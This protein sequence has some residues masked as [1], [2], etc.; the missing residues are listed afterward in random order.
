M[1]AS[2]SIQPAAD[3]AIAGP[4]D[5]FAWSPQVVALAVRLYLAEGLSA[6]EVA[7]ALG[8]GLTRCAVIAKIRRLGLR[9]RHDVGTVEAAT[10]QL[11]FRSSG[12]ATAARAASRM[13]A[14]PPIPLPPLREVPPTG[15]PAP[16][17]LLPDGRCRWPVDDP[18]PSRMHALLFC[19]GV[20]GA[21][22]YC[23]AHE[24]LAARQPTGE[25]Q[26]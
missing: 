17:V 20:T 24:A 9:K 26:A 18:G 4:P 8:G 7:A 25:G 12:R 11:G 23:A 13:P 5:T 3:A 10:A 6:S 22:R 2:L 19:A 16:L 1:P 14:W 15:V 21:G